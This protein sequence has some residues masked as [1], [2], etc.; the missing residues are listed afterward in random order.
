MLLSLFGPRVSAKANELILFK[1]S[2]T[3]Y[4]KLKYMHKKSF[5]KISKIN[6][7]FSQKFIRFEKL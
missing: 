7:Y 2:Q 5:W 6:P 4:F 1:F 3:L